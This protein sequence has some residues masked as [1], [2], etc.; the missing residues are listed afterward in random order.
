[1][2]PLADLTFSSCFGSMAAPVRNVQVR[3]RIL[4]APKLDQSRPSFSAWARQA[5]QRVWF[6]FAKDRDGLRPPAGRS[7]T[8]LDVDAEPTRHLLG[9]G[10]VLRRQDVLPEGSALQR[11]RAV[12]TAR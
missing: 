4:R 9:P 5:A 2:K 7:L 10:A 3:A 11:L 6:A 12:T 1:M 8:G